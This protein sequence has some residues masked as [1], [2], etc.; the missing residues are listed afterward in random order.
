GCA[1]AYVSS[2]VP[3][4]PH[5]RLLP[6]TAATIDIVEQRREGAGAG[7]RAAGLAAAPDGTPHILFSSQDAVPNDAW[8]ATPGDGGWKKRSLRDRK[9]TR[10]NSRH[11]KNSYAV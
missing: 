10:L 1:R 11:V 6:A 5:F 8:I 9:S 7:L 2:F 3:Y 4:S